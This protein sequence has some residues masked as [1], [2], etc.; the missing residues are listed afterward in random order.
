MPLP[1]LVTAWITVPDV[2]E[3]L[4][5]SVTTVRQF[6]REGKLVA[7]REAEGTP[8]QIPAEFVQDG[9]I[10]KS[11]PQVIG[12]LRD[13]H[14]TDDEIVEWLYTAEASLPGMPV[15]AL[16]ENRGTEVKRRAQADR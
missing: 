10:L 6:I 3:E 4:G 12:L 2:A 1:T 11:L 8:L 9:E 14:F 13:G 15:Q 5:V 16:R 7:L